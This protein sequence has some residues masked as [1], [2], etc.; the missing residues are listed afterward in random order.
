MTPEQNLQFMKTLDDSW[1]AKELTTFHKRHAKDCMVRWPNQPPT[2]GIEAH[3]Q[4][5]I[6]FFKM[7][8]DQRFVN[9]PCKI[10]LGQGEWTRR[11]A[12]LR[13]CLRPSCPRCSWAPC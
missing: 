4:E 5:A 11:T 6:A 8:P 10:M 3:E 9:N 1:N 7:F 12:N 13:L 2:H